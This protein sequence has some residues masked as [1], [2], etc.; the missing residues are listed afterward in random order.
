[1]MTFAARAAQKAAIKKDAERYMRIAVRQGGQGLLAGAIT[2]YTGYAVYNVVSLKWS[3]LRHHP[4]NVLSAKIPGVVSR[5]DND[6]CMR[7]GQLVGKV[8]TPDYQH[9]YR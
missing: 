8:G 9:T 3:I 2:A 4:D 6:K 1:M 7:E 5:S